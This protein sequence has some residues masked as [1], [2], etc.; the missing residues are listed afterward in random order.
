M[1]VTRSISPFARAHILWPGKDILRFIGSAE[2]RLLKPECISPQMARQWARAA[3]LDG[4]RPLFDFNSLRYSAIARVSQTLT[5]SCVRHGTRMD[6]DNS[7]NSLREST[8]SGGII[9][10]LKS[11]PT[12]RASSHPRNDQDE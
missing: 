4:S 7:S 11:S 9:R 2:R 3:G 1:V 6:G 12:K 5:P 8:S 10:S